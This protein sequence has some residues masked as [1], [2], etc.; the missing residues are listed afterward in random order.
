MDKKSGVT[1]AQPL[2]LLMKMGSRWSVRSS[3]PGHLGVRRLRF[4]PVFSTIR[5]SIR[6]ARCSSRRAAARSNC[7]P[8]RIAATCPVSKSLTSC[9]ICCDTCAVQ[10]FWSGITHR[11]INVTRCKRSWRNTRGSMSTTFRP[12]RRNSIRSS[13]CGHKS[14][15]IWPVG[16]LKTLSN[17]WCSSE[18][19]CIGVG[20]RRLDCGPVSTLRACHG[21]AK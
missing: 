19:P 4:G 21:N 5:A 14:T 1:W 10:S 11:F 12:A 16:R 8:S 9:A 6:S 7:V 13:M 2:Y 20:Y 18:P 17:W 3:A 15:S